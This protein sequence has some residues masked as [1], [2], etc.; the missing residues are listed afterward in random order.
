[1]ATYGFVPLS[2]SLPYWPAGLLGQ[3]EFLDE[4]GVRDFEVAEGENLLGVTGTVL[5]YREIVLG[6]PGVDTFSLAFLNEHGSKVV[7]F[8]LACCP[9]WICACPACA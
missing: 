8:S 1:M 2:Q 7:L 6:I 4:I 9:R 3:P 5:W